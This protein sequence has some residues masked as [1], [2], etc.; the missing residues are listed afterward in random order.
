MKMLDDE[1]EI[2]EL[3]PF[4]SHLNLDEQELVKISIT[5]QLFAKG[6]RLSEF[7]EEC[8]GLILVHSGRIRAYIMSQDGREITLFRLKE[9]EI[10]ILSASCLFKD[11]RFTLFFEAEVE[12]SIYIIP[13]K[14]IEFISKENM[15]LKDFFIKLL[16]KRFSTALWV[17]EQVVF[18]S[19]SSR[20]A[21]FLLDQA[22]I[23]KKLTLG[24][25]HELIAKNIGSAREVVSRMLKYFENEHLIETHRGTIFILNPDK[26][27]IMVNESEDA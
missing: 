8:Y 14:V 7:H 17:M 6:E 24:I 23:E 9:K 5:N 15:V 20:V 13:S 27:R 19:L 22:D 11:L 25:T 16:A 12:S 21:R 4:Y 18:G 10:C 2:M 1:S 3:L 26:L